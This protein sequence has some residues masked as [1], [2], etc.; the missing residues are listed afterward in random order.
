MRTT[1]SDPLDVILATKYATEVL[2][3]CFHGLCRGGK[4]IESDGMSGADLGGVRRVRSNPLN[5]N[6]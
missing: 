5:W 1:V 6:H 3:F 4:R 2:L